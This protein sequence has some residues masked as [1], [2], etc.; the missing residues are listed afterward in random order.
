MYDLIFLLVEYQIES[1]LRV[2]LDFKIV[3]DLYAPTSF[4]FVGVGKGLQNSRKI[5]PK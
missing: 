3:T 5:V 1:V 4:G 2:L